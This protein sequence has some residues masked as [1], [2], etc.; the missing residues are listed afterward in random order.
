[1]VPIILDKR[2]SKVRSGK[3]F[4]QLVPYVLVNKGREKL[5][6]LSQDQKFENILNYA[7]T[8]IDKKTNQEKCI[9]IR[10]RGITSIAS[11]T[12]EMN[13][14]SARNTRCK[15]PAFHFV[16]SWHEHDRLTHDTIFD[17]AEHA[18]KALGLA[19]HQYVV[20]IHANT[21]NPHCH[22][23]AN[24][25]HPITFKSHNI[26][27]AIKTLH[28]AARQSEIK[29]RWSHDNGIYIVQID[30]QNKKSIILN[31]DHDYTVPHAHREP[32]KEACLPTWHDPDGLD[33]W[34]KSKVARALKCALPELAD[35]NALHTW[36]AAYE[37]TLTDTGGGGM[38]LHATSPETGEVLDLPASKGLRILMRNELENRWGQ[39]AASTPEP[40]M[41]CIVPDLSH[42]TRK[43]LAK[44]V[45]AV[46]KN[47]FD[48]GIPPNPGQYLLHAEH[49]LTFPPT[50]RRG[51]LFEM[52]SGG[53]DGDEHNGEALLSDSLHIHLEDRMPR[54]EPSLRRSG[55]NTEGS[56]RS[57]TRDNSKR[58]ERKEQRAAARADLR[59]RF[60][61]YKRFAREGDTD[62]WQLT[63]SNQAARSLAL[64][65]IREETKS[66][67]SEL[68]KSRTLDIHD[69]L[70]VILAIDAESIRR[71]LQVETIYQSRYQSLRATR[72]LPLGWREWLHEQAN[73]GDQAAL[74]ALRGIVYQAQR[75]AKHRNESDNDSEEEKEA[76]GAET[77][78]QKYRKAMDRLLEEEKKEI[79]IRSSSRNAMRPYE[80][81]ALLARYIGIQWRVTGNG[82][83]EYRDKGGE[84]LFTDRGNRVTFDRTRVTDEEIRLAL[85]HAQQKFGKQLILTG[86]D[87]VFTQRMACLADDMGMTIL[88]PE[89]QSVIGHHRSARLP[90]STE[91]QIS[92]LASK[93]APLSKP[94]EIPSNKPAK[95]ELLPQ[96]SAQCNKEEI[97]LE[98]P[99]IQP[100]QTP[101]EILRAKVLSIDPRAEFVIP[102]PSSSHITYTGI[103]AATIDPTE[104]A[105]SG[106]A[107]H[108]GR[109][110]Y[111]LHLA[112]APDNHNNNA[113][114]VQHCNGQAVATVPD[115]E[116]GK[117]RND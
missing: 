37:I 27:W 109:G 80:A 102:D 87:S 20:A 1:M 48:R 92:L 88:N 79:A 34:L 6:A 49:D 93:D 113:I 42:L 73:L 61:Q 2:K 8:P 24:R 103:V 83:V 85:I 52:L 81:D 46:L 116:K 60:S 21:D 19:E 86:D 59:H 82:N 77:R 54:L 95:R 64:K 117:G 41:P 71:K 14:V 107:Q 18:I 26:E 67:K 111:A 89:L 15:D 29:H 4:N 94:I 51:S 38:R 101:H 12:I 90:L 69:R 108:I 3:P 57:L 7:T 17:A 91:V 114:N 78:E 25:I 56:R 45:N 104:G 65:T 110:V 30:G 28:L 53:L 22:I 9:A 70:L 35:W 72:L 97:P 66:A 74:S 43:Q 84:H 58:E 50:H 13:A 105:E 75:D 62:H 76:A 63:K 40:P 16:L 32:E 68:R 47:T 11:A 115:R 98:V 44:G 106:F 39:F 96:E 31:P 99:V 23:A 33:S 36:L 5:Q 55:L 112:N 100:I 10:T